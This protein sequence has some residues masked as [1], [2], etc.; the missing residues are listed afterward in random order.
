MG[1]YGSAGFLLTGTTYRRALPPRIIA[2][3]AFPASWHNS[4]QSVLRN[5]PKEVTCATPG[6]VPGL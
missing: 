1:S 3:A 4:W 6:F 5:V 2:S